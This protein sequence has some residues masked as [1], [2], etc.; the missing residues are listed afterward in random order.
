MDMEWSDSKYEH[1]EERDDESPMREQYD[2]L[3]QDGTV[4]SIIPLDF[5]QLYVAGLSFRDVTRGVGAVIRDTAGVSEVLSW[6]SRS[7][8]LEEKRIAEKEKALRLS[9][10][11]LEQIICA[12]SEYIYSITLMDGIDKV[13][14]GGAVVLTLK[15][16]NILADGDINEGRKNMRNIKESSRNSGD[17]QQ[18]RLGFP[19][20]SELNSPK[21]TGIPQFI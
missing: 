16:Q 18:K 11:F 12:T 5:V 3:Q 10:I 1:R 20:L 6:V 13:V 4:Q 2:D 17:G 19:N 14:E 15:D 9:K 8:K 21:E 7:R